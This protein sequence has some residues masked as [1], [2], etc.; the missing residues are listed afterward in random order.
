LVLQCYFCEYQKY[1]DWILAIE[2]KDENMCKNSRL[3]RKI[4][5]LERENN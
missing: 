3:M 1:C 4:S 5:I 2:I